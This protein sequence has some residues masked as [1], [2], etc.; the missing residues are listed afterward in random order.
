MEF[1]AE[2]LEH[3]LFEIQIQKPGCPLYRVIR[4]HIAMLIHRGDLPPGSRLPSTRRAA[5]RWGV[6]RRT[7]LD[8]YEELAADGLVEGEVGRGTYV[9]GEPTADRRRH[10]SHAWT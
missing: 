7:V 6:A 3:R 2:F 4:S 5:E 1:S 9:T 10:L 8:A